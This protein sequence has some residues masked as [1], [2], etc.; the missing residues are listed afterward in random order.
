VV[1]ARIVGTRQAISVAKNSS[2]GT[3]AKVRVE[4]RNLVKETTQEVCECNAARNA[5]CEPGEQQGKAFV[6]DELSD[7][8]AGGS[9]RHAQADL[10]GAMA[11]GVGEQPVD[12]D[13]GE[14]ERDA[15]E[16]GEERRLKAPW[17]EGVLV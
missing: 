11:H 15:G 12:A 1:A 16:D 3:S 17:R 5:N 4:S 6:K 7:T 14:E 10:A 9:E 13:D 2:V 8:G